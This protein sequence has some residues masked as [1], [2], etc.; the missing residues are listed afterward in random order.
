M[1][2][3]CNFSIHEDTLKFFRSI[4]FI[5]QFFTVHFEPGDQLNLS[6]CLCGFFSFSFLCLIAP[7]V[8]WLSIYLSFSLTHSTLNIEIY[9]I[10][11]VVLCWVCCVCISPRPLGMF[12]CWHSTLHQIQSA[13][14]SSL[15][16]IFHF[17]TWATQK[18]HTVELNRIKMK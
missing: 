16:I 17:L 15:I 5:F 11:Y 4:L 9:S 14:V 12:H 18:R 8:M 10:I 13:I 6:H 7:I 1:T 2:V 3:H